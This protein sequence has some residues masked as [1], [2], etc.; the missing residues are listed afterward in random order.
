MNDLR[1][2]NMLLFKNFPNTQ[3]AIDAT[4]QQGKKSTRTFD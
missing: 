1:K 4:I 3:H 2:N